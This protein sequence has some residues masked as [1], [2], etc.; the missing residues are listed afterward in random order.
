MTMKLTQA[1]IALV[2]TLTSTLCLAVEPNQWRWNGFINQG[3]VN[4][5]HNSFFGDST[6]GSFD[7]NAVGTSLSY[8]PFQ[9]LQLSAQGVY[10][11]AGET[12]KNGV[13]LDYA[14]ADWSLWSNGHWG[15]GIR[16]GRIKNPYGFYNE[17]RD[18]S[19]S[20]PSALLPQS[21]YYDSL[22]ELFHTSD[23]VSFY[24]HYETD[25]HLLTF[26]AGK[27]TPQISRPSQ[28]AILGN[29]L[30][31]ELTDEEIIFS[32]LMIE[33]QAQDWRIGW[34]HVQL[35]S[36]YVPLFLSPGTVDININMLS[37]EYTWNRWQ[38]T[39]EY[40]HRDFEFRGIQ[41]PTFSLDAPARPY[42]AQ[43]SYQINRKW[44]SLIRYDS[45]YHNK[46]DKAGK[47]FTPNSHGFA[48]DWSLGIR[49]EHN[50]HWLVSAEVHQVNGTA[51]LSREENK[52]LSQ[53]KQRWHLFAAQISWRF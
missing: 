45:I 13:Q 9:A 40:Q 30:P 48:Q 1:T 32:H 3:Y 20:R 4:T 11:G 19:A 34:T 38:F 35:S 31:G 37:A 47:D 6:G 26:H 43:V 25:D 51:W 28:N 8:R 22:R 12:S 39:T 46:Q 52:D 14:L 2:F 50:R 44:Q 10:H 5:S 21:V 36:N 24:G 29:T 18:I 15:A 33:S 23:G 27:G 7:F 17:T 53:I 42:Y 49:Y 16:A 41:S